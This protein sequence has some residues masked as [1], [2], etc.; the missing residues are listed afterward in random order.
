MYKDVLQARSKI[1]D[2][3]KELLRIIKDK[4]SFLGTISSLEVGYYA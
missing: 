1:W 2:L 3:N 4:K